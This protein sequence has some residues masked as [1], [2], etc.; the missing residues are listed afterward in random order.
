MRGIQWKASRAGV[1]GS[2]CGSD[3]WC[4]SVIGNTFFSTVPKSWLCYAGSMHWEL[5]G[6]AC[7]FG[8]TKRVLGFSGPALCSLHRAC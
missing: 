3:C 8:C 6:D 4:L 2:A 5:V 1:R 7:E